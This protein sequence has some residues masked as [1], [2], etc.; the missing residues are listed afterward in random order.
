MIVEYY[1]AEEIVVLAACA[2]DAATLVE[3]SDALDALDGLHVWCAGAER[4]RA[5]FEDGKFKEAVLCLR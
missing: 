4:A 5:K 1:Y 3:Y 2:P